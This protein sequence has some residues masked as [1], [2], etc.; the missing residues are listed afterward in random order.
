MKYAS[1]FSLI[2]ANMV[3]IV[4][5]LYWD[6]NVPA[7]MALYWFESLVVGILNVLKMIKAEGG[8]SATGITLNGTPIKDV[9]KAGLIP[10]FLL[11]YGIF[12]FV[13]GVFVVVL[14]QPWKLPLLSLLTA[15]MSLGI[16]HAISY[17]TN[18]IGKGEYRKLSA[19]QLFAAPYARILVMH[20]TI[21][22]GAAFVM[23]SGQHWVALLV[24]VLVKTVIDLISHVLEHRAVVKKFFLG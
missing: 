17:Q 7:I 2:A 22:L 18:F 1:A 11:H 8:G 14:F 3:P 6:W 12:M 21:I 9:G 15:M 13:H 23:G 5:V 10:F 24:M 20:F 4:G 19:S 16:S